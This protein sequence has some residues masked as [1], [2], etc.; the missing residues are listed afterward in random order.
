MPRY[1]RIPSQDT[2]LHPELYYGNISATWNPDV[3]GYETIFPYNQAFID[4][5]KKNIP[6]NDRHMDYDNSRTPKYIWIFKQQVLES[7]IWPMLK[8]TFTR[9]TFKLLDK[10]KVDEYNKG[11]IPPKAPI[12]KDK[13]KQEFRALIIAAGIS[14]E[15]PDKK[16]YLKAAMFYHPDRNNGNSDKMARLNEIWSTVFAPREV[17][18][19]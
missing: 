14:T 16:Q 6:G 17:E 11:F 18:L 9:A 15:L 3:E 1:R 10:A 7:I 2:N 13:L 19:V 5:I 12:D 8:A 4:F